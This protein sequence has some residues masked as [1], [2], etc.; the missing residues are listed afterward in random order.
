VLY[1]DYGNYEWL[2]REQVRNIRD[3][4]EDEDEEDEDDA[5]HDGK[6]AASTT[7]RILSKSIRIGD[8]EEQERE[9]RDKRKRRGRRKRSVESW[10]EEE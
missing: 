8:A 1:L 9:K 2:Q 5:G 3:S 4:T 10:S 6:R 7:V